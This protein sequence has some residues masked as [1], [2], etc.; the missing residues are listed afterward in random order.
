MTGSS[1]VTIVKSGNK[2]KAEVDNAASSS[3]RQTSS[4][5]SNKSNKSQ[6]TTSQLPKAHEQDV[7]IDL[8]QEEAI[9]EIYCAL[10]TKIVGIQYYNG[11]FQLLFAQLALNDTA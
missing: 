1:Q 6:A 9:D 8:T 2:R 3:G 5:K 4:S 11:V 10:R 7:D